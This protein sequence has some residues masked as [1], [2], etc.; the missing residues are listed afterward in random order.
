MQQRNELLEALFIERGQ[1]YHKRAAARCGGAYNADDVVQEAFTRALQYFP[2]YRGGGLENWFNGILLNAIKDFQ[3]ELRL[4]GMT[5]EIDETD[6]KPTPLINNMDVLRDCG[7]TL[8]K[9]EAPRTKE[10]LTLHFKNG[11]T[12]TEISSLLDMPESSVSMSIFRFKKKYLAV[13]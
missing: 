5:N 12:A 11:Y 13:I 7:L 9:A 1:G 2:S 10:V 3:R 6:V 8:A 4:E